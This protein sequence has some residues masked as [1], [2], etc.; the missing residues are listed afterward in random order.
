M[1]HIA[2]MKKSWG[3]L[4]KI[5]SGEKLIESRWRVRRTSPWNRVRKGERVYIKNTGEPVTVRARVK[6]VIQYSDL[7]PER[8]LQILQEYGQKDGLGIEDLPRFHSMF[9]DKKYCILV[10]LD[11]PEKI[12]HFNIDRKGFPAAEGW[13]TF[14]NINKI[15]IQEKP[16]QLFN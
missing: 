1:E 16:Y 6:K 5:L 14:E 15:K 7:T 13:L 12:E 10:F 2:I 9:K 4:E 3:L 8:V 11:F